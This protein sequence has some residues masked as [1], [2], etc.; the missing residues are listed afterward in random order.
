MRR[1]DIRC[2]AVSYRPSL[3]IFGRCLAVFDKVRK[4]SDHLR[5]FLRWNL[6]GN[7]VVWKNFTHLTSVKFMGQSKI[8]L[9]ANKDVKDVNTETAKEKHGAIAEYKKIFA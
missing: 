8:K 1:K 6:F 9:V 2:F 5:L 3:T 4:L 7:R